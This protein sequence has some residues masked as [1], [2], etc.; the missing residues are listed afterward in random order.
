MLESKFRAEVA[1]D[2]AAAAKSMNVTIDKAQAANLG[3]IATKLHD[4]LKESG[5]VIKIDHSA[6]E[7]HGSVSW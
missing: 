5:K 6:V 1:K 4:S 2:P 7:G 3:K